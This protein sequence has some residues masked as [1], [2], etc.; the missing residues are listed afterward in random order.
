[1]LHDRQGMGDF[2]D[3]LRLERERRKLSIE[4]IGDISKVSPRYLRALETGQYG[5]LPKGVFRKGIAR[6]YL[7][8]LDM[9]EL[10][11]MLRFEAALKQSGHGTDTS[12]DL[13]EFAEN[14]SRGRPA[15]HPV[16]RARWLGVTGMA[17]LV[18]LLGWCVWHF[19]FYGHV[20]LS[21]LHFD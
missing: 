1:M 21:N 18:G 4:S 6:G 15:S 13:T 14:I 5:E 16:S 8:A 7:G 12:G 11:W 3:D 2:C 20:A 17:L 10:P 9:D 19:V